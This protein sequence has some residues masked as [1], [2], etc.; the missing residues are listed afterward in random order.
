MM[1][2]IA[3]LKRQ[4]GATL[5]EVLVAIGLSGIMFP[6][7]ATAIIT[8]SE[9]RPTA[10]QQLLA[11]SALHSMVTA[12]RSIRD[13]D[14]NAIATDGTY[15]PSISGSGWSLLSGPGSVGSLT[16]QLVISDAQRNSSGVIVASGGNVDPSTKHIVATVSWSVPTTASM[17][18]DFY[19]TR[20]QSEASWTQTSQGDF[21]ADSLT[22]TTVTNLSGGEVELT[23]GQSSGTVE[24]S[25][26]DATK[27]V[28]FNFLSFTDNVPAGTNVQFQIAT[29]NDNATWNFV[30]PD[31]TGSSFYTAP[32]AISLSAVSGR[33]IRYLAS[34][35]TTNASTPVLDDITLT[36]SP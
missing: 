16:E 20:W 22:N 21:S 15:H 26:F 32:G 12:T 36:Y 5:V 3:P 2:K 27:A 18:S 19:L 8:S 35:S 29:N 11:A 9:A 28:G 13:Q 31:G 7:L 33:Y 10:T 14:W 23:P 4:T 24:S 6:V 34:F 1:R 25:T 17:T 30:G